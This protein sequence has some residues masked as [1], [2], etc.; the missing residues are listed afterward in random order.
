MKLRHLSLVVALLCAACAAAYFLQRPAPPAAPDARVG[1]P[2]LDAALAAGAA[3]VRLSDLG[4]SVTVRRQPDGRWIVPDYHHF[5]ADFTKLGRLM[6]E[7]SEAKIQRFVTSRPDRLARLDFK[8]TAITL[9]DA[10]GQELWRLALG[11]TA[12]GGGRYVR[13]GTEEK[14]YQANLSSWLDPEPKNWADTTLLQ[15]KPEEV[16]SVEL[17]FAEGDPLKVSRPAKDAAW[18]TDAA[19]AGKQLRSDRISSLLASVGQLR[20]TETVDPADPGVAAARA[21]A[22]TV[23]LGT[24]DGQ[25]YTITLGRKPEEKKPKPPAAPA[26]TAEPKAGEPPAEAKPPEPE[27]DTIPAG[28]VFVAVTAS[29]EQAAV[30]AMMRQRAFQ[31]GEWTFTG[32]PAHAEDFW[33]AAPAP[34][35]PAEAKP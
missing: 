22:R 34:T 5:R 15:L 7:L 28:P 1:Q 16:A 20:F 24:F 27:F 13:F 25:A 2:L 11:K 8:D 26:P 9:L 4:K 31:I 10:G 32:L 19:P 12:E 35:P 17:T 18:T 3:E 33:E 23:K 14:A 30:N 6:N 21:H 29:D